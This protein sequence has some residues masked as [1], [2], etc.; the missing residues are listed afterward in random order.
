MGSRK[1]HTWIDRPL[2]DRNEIIKRHNYVEALI[3]NYVAKEEIKESL[4]TVYDLE[5]IIG[6]ISVG[7]A[8]AKDLV[9]LRRSLAN[10]PN[11]KKNVMALGTDD[12]IS[13]ANGIDTHEK[14]YDLL[15]KALVDDPPLQIKEGGM[16]KPLYNKD[17]DELKEIS[18][19]SKDWIL[20][21]E[22]QERERTGI[23]TM[24]VGYNRVFGYYIEV[25]KGA[26]QN[27]TDS[28]HYE[29]KQTL[30]NAERFITPELK[31]YE[32]IVVGSTEKI[33]KLEYDLFIEIRDVCQGFTKSLQQ[34]ADKISTID[35]LLAFAEV[36]VKYLSLIHI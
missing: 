26:L 7:N 18:G 17:L 21:F 14:L 31:K 9:Q 22:A 12:A 35:C 10:I 4:K 27:L 11:F 28:D 13:F 30:A 15:D 3:N 6:R 19:S 36:S 5:R 34:L 2:I 25:S 1:L 20:K 29:R 23:K 32:Q 8:N 24:H 33:Q 16:I